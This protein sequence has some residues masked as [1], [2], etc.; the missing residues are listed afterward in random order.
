M[1]R[2]KLLSVLKGAVTALLGG[3]LVSALQYLGTVDW[4][5]AGPLV[6]AAVSVAISAARKALQPTTPVAPKLPAPGDPADPFSAN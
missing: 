1:N 5:V 6:G 3:G 4:G 2:E